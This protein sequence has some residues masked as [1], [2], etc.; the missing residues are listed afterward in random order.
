MGNYVMKCKSKMIQLNFFFEYDPWH[1]NIGNLGNQTKM[2]IETTTKIW[3]NLWE[4]QE[5][6]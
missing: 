3:S 2:L 5:Q 4:G 6:F 1:G